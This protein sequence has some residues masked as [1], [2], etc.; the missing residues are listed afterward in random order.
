VKNAYRLRLASLLATA[1]LALGSCSDSYG[2]FSSVQ[3]ETKQSGT[4]YF[5]KNAITGFYKLSGS[6]Y[7]SGVKLYTRLV[8]GDTDSWSVTSINGSKDYELKA[9]AANG[10][11]GLYVSLLD[12][13]GDNRL[14]YTSDG[15][16]WTE[17]DISSFVTSADWIDGLFC[18]G[19]YLFAQVHKNVANEENDPDDTY[20]LYYYNL[21]LTYQ[22]AVSSLSAL[23]YPMT[24]VVYGNSTYWY[25]VRGSE[26]NSV[27]GSLYTGAPS[28]TLLPVSGTNTPAAHSAVITSIGYDTAYS[29]G[30]Y[31]GSYSGYLYHYSSDWLSREDVGSGGPL[32][33]L[34]FVSDSK[35][36]VGEGYDDSTSSDG[37]YYEGVWGSYK[38]GDKDN[39]AYVTC[40]ESVDGFRQG[41]QRFLF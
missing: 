18:A 31:V 4:D 3:K 7:A 21:P 2:V 32:A 1:L 16:S 24:G 27:A 10:T 9:V 40:S 19:S 11:S 25:A 23:S 5:K 12:S 15:S 37:G 8:T 17:T 29:T 41:S 28:G 33:A 26:V 38:T 39:T 22:G 14:L 35:M 6:Y 30:L 34:G 20:A 13:D 36:L